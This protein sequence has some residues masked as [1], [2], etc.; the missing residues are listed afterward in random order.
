MLTPL[1]VVG[2]EGI[3]TSMSVKQSQHIVP[4]ADMSPTLLSTG[5]ERKLPYVSPKDYIIRAKLDGKV[6]EYD[7]NNKM[8]IV[9][10]KDHTCEAINLNPVISKNGGGGFYLSNILKFNMKVGQSFKKDDILAYHQ[11]YFSNNFDGTKFNL[12][13]LC[14]CAIMSSYATF[15]DAKMVTERLANRMA[16]EIVMQKHIILGPNANVSHIVKV[17]DTVASGDSLLTFE[18]S[19]DEKAINKLLKNIGDELKEDIRTMGRNT[20][21]TKYSGVVEDIRIYST[22]ELENLSP[23]LQKIVKE[24]WLKI[25]NKKKLIRKYAITDA[26]YQGN[27]FYEIS[28]PIRPDESGRVKGHK[29]D[30]G[31]I[32]EFY[33]KYQDRLKPGDKLCD[34]YALKGVISLVIPEGQEP[35]TIGKPNEPIDTCFPASSVLARMVPQVIKTMFIQK[36]LV[37]LRMQLHGMY[38]T[39]FSHNVRMRMEKYIYDVFTKLDKTG[40]N[41]NFYKAFFSKMKDNEFNN[42]FNKFFADKNG[43]LT[44]NVEI[45][46]NEPSMEE[47]ESCAKFMNVPLYEYVVQPYFSKDKSKPMVTPYPVP[48][49]Y[50]HEKRVQQMAIKKNASSTEISMRDA[51]TNQVVAADK[52]GRNSIDENYAMMTYGAK[53]AVKEFMSIRSDDSVMKEEAYSQIRNN[54]YVEMATLQDKLENKTTLN[55]FDTYLISMGIKTDL[56]SSGYVLHST[57]TE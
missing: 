37:E 3:R 49:G 17:G 56:I 39:K 24:Y 55:T 27:T 47:I 5:V 14:K 18:Q 1:G 34:E 19:N 38:G 13:T 12:G 35:Y 50:I 8:V 29:I 51:K 46:E 25:K 11:D 32:F 54:G 36:L 41:T 30:E 40:T 28:E 42:F 22:E 48:V 6:V 2:D 43:F 26:S 31:I 53:A 15:E 10:Y 21:K 57:Q 44:L 45:F 52:N 33:I 20:L 4:T 7:K 23:S 16:T 9:K